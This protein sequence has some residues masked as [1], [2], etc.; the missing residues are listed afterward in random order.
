MWGKVN[1][2]IKTHKKA[3][4]IGVPIVIILISGLIVGMIRYIIPPE[5]TIVITTPEKKEP[6]KPIL[7]ASLLNGTL[8]SPEAK[9]SH[10]IA[11]MIENSSAA[12]PQVGL[13]SADVVYEAV[14][15]GGI[16]RFMALYS[17][18]Y[19][20]KSGPIR[21]ARSFFIDWHSEFDAF[22]VHAG[23]S[24]TALSRISVYGIKDY[25]HSNDGTYKREPIAGVAS[26]HT[27]FADISKIFT[28]SITK[29]GWPATY[30]FSSWKFKDPEKTVALGGTLSIN[31]SSPNYA[32]IWEYD[33]T[34]NTFSRKMAGV[35]HKD[36]LTGEQITAE[37]VI[38]MTVKN[39]PNAPY[40]NGKQSE[41][42]MDTIGSGNASVFID[43]KQIRGT[44]EKPS[45]KERTRFFNETDVEIT[46][47]RGNIWVEVIP[48]TGS[49]TFTPE[50]PP[51]VEETPET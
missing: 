3:V 43:G 8:V 39:S 51:V 13:T 9:N 33:K 6:P 1:F 16:T 10:V 47:N 37:T 49:Y 12:R 48:Q 4:I 45:R 21:S 31:F 15:E 17:Q 5:N 2:W 14:T 30:D 25:P 24:P 11:V 41:W 46:L 35:A 20:E 18:K 23:G 27:L 32:V 38:V 29:K 44:W 40:A 7:V 19:P 28:N 26:E 42:T 34:A 36:R 22:Y 50:T